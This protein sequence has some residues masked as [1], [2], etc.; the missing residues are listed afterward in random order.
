MFSVVFTAPARV[1][2]EDK[3]RTRSLSTLDGVDCDDCF[4]DYFRYNSWMHDVLSD[5][6][7]R[8]EYDDECNELITITEYTS[9]R[10]LT[11]EEL[12][13][14]AKYTQGQWSDGIGEGFEQFPQRD[15]YISAWYRGQVVSWYVTEIK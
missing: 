7:M 12:K 15:A 9:N 13:E 1:G 11:E 4:S 10:E 3:A 14:V 2:W 5:G 8:F 6:Y